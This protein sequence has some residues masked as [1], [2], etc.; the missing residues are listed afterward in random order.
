MFFDTTSTL[1]T[2]H[3]EWNGYL[4]FLEDDELDQD[5]IYLFIFWTFQR[6]P[7]LLASGLFGMVFEHLQDC[8]HP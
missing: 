6:M 5:F 2:L 7:H 3:H 4:F 1:T 8:F